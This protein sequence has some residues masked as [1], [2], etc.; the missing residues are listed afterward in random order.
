MTTMDPTQ[1]K[2]NKI[3]I[4]LKWHWQIFSTDMAFF[5][6][7]DNYWMIHLLA[8]AKSHIWESNY[9]QKGAAYATPKVFSFDI[10]LMFSSTICVGLT[11][12]AKY[13]QPTLEC[14]VPW[15]QKS[16]YSLLICL[17]DCT[18]ILFPVCNSPLKCKLTEGSNDVKFI[19]VL[20]IHLGSLSNNICW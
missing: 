15:K 20:W 3:K 11:K 1:N 12:K 17:S 2:L 4:Q 14:M 6:L 16:M 18:W 9:L 8:I 13:P 7:Q 19:I 5:P 10:Y